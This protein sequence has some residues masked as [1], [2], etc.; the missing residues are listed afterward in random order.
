MVILA[1]LLLTSCVKNYSVTLEPEENFRVEGNLNLN[2]MIKGFKVTFTVI[3]PEGKEVDEFT[4]DGEVKDL[5]NLRYTLV[6]T[7][8][9]K[10]KV[11]FKDIVD[12]RRT[13]SLNLGEGLSANVDN[14]SKIKEGT[15]VLITIDIPEGQ[16]LD[17]L[18]ID[19]EVISGFTGNTYVLEVTKNH[20][21]TA[22]FKN[23]TDRGEY[24]VILGSGLSSGDLLTGL[25]VGSYV[26]VIVAIPPGQEIDEFFVD[27]RKVAVPTGN[28]YVLTVSRNHSLQVTFKDI[29]DSDKFFVSLGSGLSSGDSLT[30]LS[31]GSRLTILV[32]VPPGKEIDQ[33]L[34]DG[35]PASVTSRN[36]YVL[37]VSKNHVVSVTFKDI[38]GQERYSV[39]LGTGLSSTDPLTELAP[40]TR[41]QVRINI[42][43]GKEIDQLV[44]DGVVVTTPTGRTYTITVSKNHVVSVTFK[45]IG[46][47]SRYSVSL[48]AGLSSSSPLTSLSAGT[49]VTINIAIPPG[50]EINQL[51][52]DGVAVPTP[53]GNT[54]VLTIS[55][56]HVLSVTF[57]D[58]TNE[59][60]MVT[61]KLN[62][63]TLT[64]LDEV[65]AI[66]KG[67]TVRKPSGDP[68]KEGH[69]FIEWRLYGV[70]YNFSTPVTENITLV[71]HYR[72]EK[73]QVTFYVG[74]EQ[75]HSEY[76]DHGSLLEPYPLEPRE[77]MKG[78]WLF[79]GIAYDFSKP[80]TSPLELQAHYQAEFDITQRMTYGNEDIVITFSEDVIFGADISDKRAFLEALFIAPIDYS[81]VN[82]NTINITY[83]NLRLTIAVG[84]DFYYHDHFQVLDYDEGNGN[85]IVRI[86]LIIRKDSIKTRDKN[87]IYQ[88]DLSDYVLK[89]YVPFA[90]NQA[91]YTAPIQSKFYSTFAASYDSY[92]DPVLE[93][94]VTFTCTET[95]Y[96]KV[97]KVK[98]G[99]KV[100]RP[101]EP[102]KNNA[103]FVNWL[104]N[105]EK[106][107]FNQ[108][109][110]S[111]INLTPRWAD[112]ESMIKI[113]FDTQSPLYIEPQVIIKGEKPTMPDV[114]ELEGYN[115]LGW[116][117]SRDDIEFY[118]FQSPLNLNFELV[119]VWEK[120]LIPVTINLNGGQGETE[121]MWPYGDAFSALDLLFNM[122]NPP[123]KPGY[124]FGG[125]KQ[126]FDDEI[127]LY[128]PIT[129]D[130]I[131]LEGNTTITFN[132]MYDDRVERVNIA[133]DIVY[134]V[135]MQLGD[136]NDI[137]YN[138]P[139]RPGYVFGGWYIDEDYKVP[140]I[141]NDKKA[142]SSNY[143]AKWILDDS[144]PIRKYNILFET[145]GGNHIDDVEVE[146]GKYLDIY[147]YIPTKYGYKFDGWYVDR[148]LKLPY[149]PHGPHYYDHDVMLFA[150]WVESDTS[151]G[152]LVTISF[153]TNYPVEFEPIQV[154]KGVSLPFD[155]IF[156]IYLYTFS[157][158]EE[159]KDHTFVGWFD[160]S[161]EH[162]LDL[163]ADVVFESDTTLYALWKKC[164]AISGY[165]GDKLVFKE[166]L[167]SPERL[168]EVNL[169]NFVLDK[170]NLYL[171][172]SCTNKLLGSNAYESLVSEDLT[173]YLK[174]KDII[175]I[176]HIEY[177]LILGDG[178]V[179]KINS[180]YRAYLDEA[181][182]EN[183]GYG[184]I[185]KNRMMDG[186]YTDEAFNTPITVKNYLDYVENGK[187]NMYVKWK[188]VH[189]IKVITNTTDINLFENLDTIVVEPGDT[190]DD[191]I[192]KFNHLDMSKEGYRFDGAYLDPDFTQSGLDVENVDQLI[193]QTVYVKWEKLKRVVVRVDTNGIFRH[194]KIVVTD[195]APNLKYEGYRI[196]AISET[197]DFSSEID[198]G[199][200]NLH[201]GQVIY[202]KLA[203]VYNVTIYKNDTEVWR[204][205]EVIEGDIIRDLDKYSLPP[206][207]DGDQMI[208][209]W[210]L[211]GKDFDL[212]QPF[213]ADVTDCELK[214][215]WGPVEYLTVEFMV[216][217]TIKEDYTQSDVLPG[218]R[219]TD[220]TYGL[221]QAPYKSGYTFVY[222]HIEDGMEFTNYHNIYSN[223]I[224]YALY[225]ANDDK[226]VVSYNTDCNVAI[227]SEEVRRYQTIDQLSN[228]DKFKLTKSGYRF[229]GWVYGDGSK[230]S[231][232][233]RI[234]ESI[235][236]TAYWVPCETHPV[237]LGFNL[238]PPKTLH[239]PH[240][241][242]IYMS[243]YYLL[244]EYGIF[245]NQ[246]SYK[247]RSF[248][249]N[250]VDVT[251]SYYSFTEPDVIYV[252]LYEVGPATITFM[253]GSET[254]DVDTTTYDKQEPFGYLP[255][256][257]NTENDVFV[258]WLYN[259]EPVNVDT[260]VVGDMTLHA[261]FEPK[262]YIAVSF[263][264]NVTGIEIEPFQVLKYSTLDEEQ[265]RP[266]TKEN[267]KFKY[268]AREGETSRFN[269]YTEKITGPITLVAVW[270]EMATYKLTI[271]LGDGYETVYMYFPQNTSVPLYE[272]EDYYDLN[273]NLDYEF[274]S[275]T[276]MG[277]TKYYQ[278][279]TIDHNNI[280]LKAN[281]QDRTKVTITFKI[282]GTEHATIKNM[283][284]NT[285][286]NDNAT[287]NMPQD[288]TREGY[289]FLGWFTAA[290]VQ[291]D[292]N[293]VVTE[294]MELHANWGELV[295]VT[296]TFKT[297]EGVHDT[298]SIYSNTSISENG[299]QM[300]STPSKSGWAFLGW[301]TADDVKF[302]KDSIVTESIIVTAYW[303]WNDMVAVR[304]LVDKFFNYE[305]YMNLHSRIYDHGLTLPEDPVKYGYRFTGWVTEDGNPFD[306]YYK[307]VEPRASFLIDAQFEPKEMVTLS[308][309][310]NV[311]GLEIPNAIVEKNEALGSRKPRLLTKDNHRFLGWY[312]VD[313]ILVNEDYVVTDNLT[314]YAKWEAAETR[315]LTVELGEGYDSVQMYFPVD[316][317]LKF[318]NLGTYY[319]INLDL[320]KNFTK[321]SGLGYDNLI[322]YTVT[323][324]NHF[325]VNATWKDVT[326]ATITFMVGEEFYTTMTIPRN[327]SVSDNW[328]N[329]WPYNPIL[330]HHTYRGW[331]TANGEPFDKYTVIT[332]D[333]TVYANMEQTSFPV[334]FIDRGETYDV[335][336]ISK[337][338]CFSGWHHGDD[339]PADP[340]APQYHTFLGWYNADGVKFTKDTI[341]NEA[342]TVYAKW[343]D[344]TPAFVT[345][346]NEGANYETLEVPKGTA[347]KNNSGVN[348][349]EAPTRDGYKFLGWKTIDEEV[350]DINYVVNN[351]MSVYASWGDMSPV[352]LTFNV[353]G[354]FYA[355]IDV[356]GYTSINENSGAGISMPSNP[357]K[358]GHRFTCWRTEDDVMFTKDTIVTGPMIINA[359]WSGT[360]L[361]TINCV[362]NNYSIGWFQIYGNSRITDYTDRS[363]PTE[364]ALYSY[365]RRQFHQHTGWEFADGT[366][367]D[368]YTVVNETITVFAKYEPIATATISFVTN[369]AGFTMNDMTIAKNEPLGD[370]YQPIT[371]QNHKFLGWYTIDDQE[372][373][374]EYIVTGDITLYAKWEEK[375]THTI[376]VHLREGYDSVEMYFPKGE[377]LVFSTL[378]DHYDL[379]PNRYYHID[380]L[381]LHGYGNVIAMYTNNLN[382]DCE[383]TANF[384]DNTPVMITFMVDD[385]YYSSFI[386]HVNKKIR[387]Y[388]R[389]YIRNPE[390][391]GYVFKGWKT[392]TGDIF[393]DYTVVTADIT[394][395][396]YWE[397]ETP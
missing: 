83:E 203:K 376:T 209:A 272:L 317:K 235:N 191:L 326:P 268:W 301:Y 292:A 369:R 139:E 98:H 168:S 232:N 125:F 360:N 40:G 178:N 142:F 49:K 59:V 237:I 267:H 242:R 381:D 19:G 179:L 130:V 32:N 149:Y 362:I 260:I 220:R 349:P 346:V 258:C 135:L 383:I 282:D 285:C 262:E 233:D 138:A 211:N 241:E 239:I 7:K 27:G 318:A 214:P 221:P 199:N 119:A 6:I 249:I 339:F 254:Y 28:I 131:W 305:I 304:F 58:V 99:Q 350:F 128:E 31:L 81:R 26:T 300:P 112:A 297:E 198:F 120:I 33:F 189:Y 55:K 170:Y 69:E 3:V 290:E 271:D 163:Y 250:D 147:E 273:P 82:F 114:M 116:K 195:T 17:E 269:F 57:K 5:E 47:P 307:I 218:T 216:D 152:E 347:I 345:F 224:L 15:N 141:V 377:K 183:I 229:E 303:C 311:P 379:N 186:L 43:E 68:V 368:E 154:S 80:V 261:K 85:G 372:I 45:D 287:I 343:Q 283:P 251:G 330:A 206:R 276:Y 188:D 226:V 148:D 363:L 294:S 23:L 230:V 286:I 134:M 63:G 265:P 150:K 12:N 331:L 390:R 204:E 158:R 174:E 118:D 352:T 324:Q 54:Y 132:Y 380:R 365:Q 56:N 391:A 298:R 136:I 11:T 35:V 108:E 91:D 155:E 238:L 366:P 264:T 106:F 2:K 353:D 60:M 182:L 259:G 201:E 30:G 270:E 337:G 36:T 111:N 65:Q 1:S 319:D 175:D 354:G 50:K 157:L 100:N 190:M 197:P 359:R 378:R 140:F 169:P 280:V 247:A 172:Q 171:D 165:L 173:I 180:Q 355:S 107:N 293:Y 386:V 248:K 166:Y 257:D 146:V 342:W 388:D 289:K 105:G 41:I 215:S 231:S 137:L 126:L 34:V 77:G 320:N 110:R 181:F 341:V 79:N 213:T 323:I 143:Y 153:V 156:A 104:V 207:Q 371:K 263:I 279:I 95:G 70:K 76:I 392:S 227:P 44:V 222:W 394:V 184:Y 71:A 87:L 243:F 252:E 351:S 217:G 333:I 42:P 51:I 295:P 124:L 275:Y 308:F 161:Y 309:V 200:H 397:P 314:I 325:T 22:I 115:F 38:P 187:L 332:E 384:T 61:F 393:D 361:V 244:I 10:L 385:V 101:E 113:S 92:S 374:A 144:E 84:N 340:P 357:S 151:L 344:N 212:S 16:E 228:Y 117:L 240:N 53:S 395:Y 122:E 160:S 29:T 177:N 96:E 336:Y 335:H 266:L 205:Y 25:T 223:L 329:Y 78:F 121:V 358:D 255:Q 18:I 8:N 103:I 288:P 145:N 192:E 245:E 20:V 299:L 312:T 14:I 48:G 127:Y 46:A 88:S 234:T 196:I 67:S 370:K 73:Y 37:V 338:Q 24:N 9:H 281:W 373:T 64:G 13:F 159:L 123:T 39:T 86:P 133:N 193:G 129:L 310:S 202:V 97:V 164:I 208:T 327:T 322:G 387:N 382:Q 253:N 236:L 315:T 210:M 306:E 21:V 274:T 321:F 225:V 167:K 313:D 109:I 176:P 348:L 302:N 4:V 74:S 52:V 278:S 94:D 328:Y 72:A 194:H 334:T 284:K 396:A 93:H 316:F 90:E 219:F 356:P 367:F 375:E 256:L 296:V 102:K 162:E 62:G 66:N 389:K 364:S 246:Q 75:V 277:E 291:F 89:L 185:Y